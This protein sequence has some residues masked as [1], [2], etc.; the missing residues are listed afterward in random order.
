MLH[1]GATQ[2][3]SRAKIHS[4]KIVVGLSLLDVQDLQAL[5]FG[6]LCPLVGSF[7][8]DLTPCVWVVGVHDV[9]DLAYD[10]RRV[11][12]T[13]QLFSCGW[14]FGLLDEGGTARFE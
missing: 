1:G 2:L 6:F 3:V 12:A 14:L 5:P 10:E 9:V 8:I 13:H 4:S 7:P 11:A